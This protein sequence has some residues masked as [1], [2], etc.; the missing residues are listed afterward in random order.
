MAFLSEACCGS[1]AP[2]PTG[3]AVRA[4]RQPV[5]MR[6]LFFSFP[7]PCPLKRKGKYQFGNE[8]HIGRLDRQRNNYHAD[9]L[10]RVRTAME[11]GLFSYL[12]WKH[13]PAGFLLPRSDT[14]VGDC[15]P[16]PPDTLEYNRDPGSM[17]AEEDSVIS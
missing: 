3:C 7:P 1:E 12:S 8:Q 13:R 17:V 11:D 14:S 9:M 2:L 6:H 4:R 10:C 5:W 16:S 15:S